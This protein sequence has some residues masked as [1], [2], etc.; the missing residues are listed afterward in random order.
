MNC[1]ETTFSFRDESIEYFIPLS[2]AAMNFGTSP[3]LPEL[4]SSQCGMA[5]DRILSAI[6]R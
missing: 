4:P 6:G 2:V 5:I 1:F 3:G